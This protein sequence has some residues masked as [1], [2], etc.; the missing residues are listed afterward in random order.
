MKHQV[1]HK[2]IAVTGATGLIGRSICEKFD[3][4]I[5]AFEGDISKPDEIF[6]FLFSLSDDVSAL[7]HLAAIVPKQVVDEKVSFSTNVNIQ[8]TVHV[9]E[10]LRQLKQIGKNVPWLFY[11]STSH[12]YQSS[13]E[14]VTEESKVNP[15]TLYGLSKLHGEQWCQAFQREF[16]LEICMGRIFSFS[17]PEQPDYYFL[18]AMFKKASQA[19]INA[20]IA[21]PGVM[22]KR[23]FLRVEQICEVIFK[24]MERRAEGVFNIGSGHG[25]ILK[26]IVLKISQLLKRE[27]IQWEFL[28][29]QP[30]SLVAD[31]SKLGH[32]DIHIE[33]E[34]DL[35]LTE[36]RDSCLEK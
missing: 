28:Q 15:F 19:P 10:A 13:E 25:H 23:D 30:K 18:P 29:D 6:R 2:K 22:G 27:D 24:L 7:L 11:A 17:S 1:E 35:L 32:L 8:G 31:T 4:E 33:D 12:C 14:P 5:I 34:L 21:V 36:M 20:R 26:D 3:G 16:Q 9:L